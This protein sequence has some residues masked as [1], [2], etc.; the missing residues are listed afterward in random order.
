MFNMKTIAVAVGVALT[1]GAAATAQAATTTISNGSVTAAINDGGTFAGAWDPSGPA[2]GSPGLNFLGTEF[3]N[4][5]NPSAWWTLESSLG[6]MTA[7]YGSVPAG[8]VTTAAGSDAAT[9][10][11][12]TLSF[13]QIA[14]L[15]DWNQLSVQ[16]SFTNLGTTAITGA[17]Y[18]VGFDPDQGGSGVNATDNYIEG[19]GTSAAVRASRVLADGNNWGVTLANTTSASAYDIRAYVN[20]GD[21]CSVVSPGGVLGGAAQSVGFYSFADDSISLAYDLGTIGVGQT[22]SIGYS[23]TM[24]IPEPE[25]YAMLLAGLGLMGFVAR[26]RRQNIAA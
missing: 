5:D 2:A 1:V 8:S 13:T 14:R 9:T 15:T 11:G 3:M 6:T 18:G 17:H 26:R 22:V 19:Q 25:T 4:I 24:A 20:G 23:Y 21:C 12:G 16:V 10:L 7:N